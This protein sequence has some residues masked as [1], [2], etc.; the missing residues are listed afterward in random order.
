MLA[1][2]HQIGE[3][4]DC[5]ISKQ[6]QQHESG[7][8]AGN[9]RHGESLHGNQ[10]KIASFFSH[11]AALRNPLLWTIAARM[12]GTGLTT[13]S[14]HNHTGPTEGTGDSPVVFSLNM[15]K[16]PKQGTSGRF[17]V[18]AAMT[19]AVTPDVRAL[20]LVDALGRRSIVLVGIMGCGKSSVGRR[21]AQRLGL[22]FVDADAEIE[23][24]ANMTISEIFAAHGEAEFRR[25]EEKV[26]ARLLQNGPQILA[27]GGGAFI[28][29][30]P[31]M[32]IADAG[33]SVWLKAVLETVFARVSKRSNRPLLRNPDPKGVLTKLMAE[34]DPIYAEAELTVWSRDVPHETVMNDIISAVEGHLG[35]PSLEIEEDH[36]DE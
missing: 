22:P 30:H 24:A 6:A 17:W 8:Q 4:I 34:R 19:D 25:G 7:N 11:A 33:I 29:A 13:A 18:N 16:G 20:R 10:K 21:L 2:R 36:P 9:C 28:I 3:R 27:T 32:A 15:L 35:L 26:I 23:A 12:A 1:R 31:R 14:P 5:A